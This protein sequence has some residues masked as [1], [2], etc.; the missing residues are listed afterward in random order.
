MDSLYRVKYVSSVTAVSYLYTEDCLTAKQYIEGYFNKIKPVQVLGDQ[1][2]ILSSQK[3]ILHIG[4][5]ENKNSNTIISDV[6]REIA[7]VDPY[8]VIQGDPEK[9]TW[10]RLLNYRDRP[11]D[12][13]NNSEEDFLE[14]I[15]A[16][17]NWLRSGKYIPVT[18]NWYYDEFYDKIRYT[19]HDGNHRLGV[20]KKIGL[21][22]IKVRLVGQI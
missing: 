2:Q 17:A 12:E 7:Y 8:D 14:W 18:C 13:A 20:S 5:L 22:N 19:A 3:K 10:D 4:L 6:D 21:D 15:D 16:M 1:H 9:N 11:I